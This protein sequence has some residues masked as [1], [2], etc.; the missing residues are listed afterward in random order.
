MENALINENSPY[1]KKHAKNPVQWFS[2]KESII[3][4]AKIE[5]KLIL[6]S[7]GYHACHWCHVMEKESFEANDVALIMNSNYLSIKVDKEERPDIDMQM[8]EICQMLTGSGGWPLHVIFLPNMKPI[9]AGT[10]FPKKNWMNLLENIA[11]QYKNNKE[12]LL[13]RA[14]FIYEHIKEMDM[15]QQPS[16]DDDI[17]IESLKNNIDNCLQNIDVDNG[18]INGIPKFIMPEFWRMLM[19]NT[20]LN[21]NEAVKK[22]IKYSLYKF[23]LGG[24][25]DQVEGGFA[26]YCVDEKWNIPHFEKM[27]YDNAQI[28][29]LYSEAYGYFK[30]DIYKTIVEKTIAF[31]DENLN[32]GNNLFYAS[33]DADS[34][35]EEG[36]YYTETYPVLKNI[37]LDKFDLFSS[38]FNVTSEGNWKEKNTNILYA[39]N[40]IEVFANEQKLDLS[41]TEKIIKNALHEIKKYRKSKAKPN[42]DTK[43]ILAW[44]AMMVSALT[45]ASSYL[46]TPKYLEMAEKTAKIILETFYIDTYLYRVVYVKNRIQG[47]LDDYVSV[48][49]MC[50]KLYQV[51]GK[52]KYFNYAEKIIAKAIIL[53]YDNETLF[54]YNYKKEGKIIRPKYEIQDNVIP[55]SNA[56]FADILSEMFL[57]T[58]NESYKNIYEKMCQHMRSEVSKNPRFYSRWAQVFLKN[59]NTTKTHVYIGEKAQKAAKESQ[60]MYNPFC[61]TVFSSNENSIEIFKN[62]YV[63][64]KTLQYICENNTCKMAIEI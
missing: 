38:Y 9:F 16:N 13:E 44:N 57:L 36:K 23:A 10:Y 51:T 40:T 34:E 42:I 61:F 3:N 35:G 11:F 19:T 64:G 56:V 17:S 1:L 27:L 31:I 43:I 49:E 24:I 63:K 29:R 15:L 54:Y 7:V 58:T 18:G 41:N 62:R 52:N 39:N 37:L 45:D 60:Q 46:N 32:N 25:H 50:V 12:K 55:S 21:S 30:D 20:F 14:D 53:F 26:R 2:W 6:V 59:L 47:F 4:N 48:I 5:D 8:M 28:I 22:E 33:L